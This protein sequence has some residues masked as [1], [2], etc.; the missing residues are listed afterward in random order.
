MTTYILDASAVL[1]LLFSERGKERV[2]EILEG[3]AIGRI[4][5]TEILTKLVER[6]ASMNEATENFV[7]LRISVIELDSR[8]P[9]KIAELRPHTKQIGLSL[10]DRACPA[11]VIQ[12][13]ATAITADRSWTSLNVC[14]IETIR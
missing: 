13:N 6:G 14:P 2:E 1:A 12:E 4:N 9:E 8:Q 3:S 7:D 11:L 5:A 10:G